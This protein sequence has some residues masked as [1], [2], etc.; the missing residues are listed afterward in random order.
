[1]GPI[2]FPCNC[3]GSNVY[4]IPSNKENTNWIHNASIVLIFVKTINIKISFDQKT[5]RLKRV[6]DKKTIRL[7]SVS[8]INRTMWRS[9]VPRPLIITFLFFFIYVKIVFIETIINHNG[10]IRS[11][12]LLGGNRLTLEKLHT[13]CRPWAENLGTCFWRRRF[14]RYLSV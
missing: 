8:K 4:G 12:G 14:R 3:D 9:C 11:T 2:Y 10:S 1:M 5:T 13:A 7:K 6:K